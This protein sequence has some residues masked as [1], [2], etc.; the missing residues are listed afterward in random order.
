MAHHLLEIAKHAGAKT[1][2]VSDLSLAKMI[3]HLRQELRIVFVS[4]DYHQLA[5]ACLLWGVEP[6]KSLSAI[7]SLHPKERFVDATN[8]HKSAVI[9]MAH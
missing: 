5:Q 8:F 4:K 2:L 3:S 1:I 6:V 9:Q 7:S